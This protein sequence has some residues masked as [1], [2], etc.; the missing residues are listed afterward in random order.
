MMGGTSIERAGARPGFL[1]REAAP[2]AWSIERLGGVARYI[3]RLDGG[4][5]ESSG[6]VDDATDLFVRQAGQL[7]GELSARPPRDVEDR[8]DGDRWRV[9]GR[10]CRGRVQCRRIVRSVT[11]SR[12]A[13]SVV[14]MSGCRSRSRRA[15]VAV[16][17]LLVR[18]GVRLSVRRMSVTMS[19]RTSEPLSAGS[20]AGTGVG[21]AS[22][23]GTASSA[24][25]SRPAISTRQ[26]DA[27]TTTPST[28]NGIRCAE[29]GDSP[30][31]AQTLTMCQ[32]ETQAAIP[33][34]TALCRACRT[35]ATTDAA[36]PRASAARTAHRTRLSWARVIG[37]RLPHDEAA[38]QARQ[39]ARGRHAG[40][41]TWLPPYPGP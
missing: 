33:S 26:T 31:L 25:R 14:G 28:E 30:Y 3:R 24:A 10:G 5:C 23:T 27:T 38:G 37:R 7:D 32:Y 2:R 29:V 21:G 6:G 1:G 11:P 15:A 8:G 18:R 17:G 16:S 13:M 34:L 9:G 12:R 40:S 19:A 22:V 20:G 39:R 35:L 4:A 36:T 41:R